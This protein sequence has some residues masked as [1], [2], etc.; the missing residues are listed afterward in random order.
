MADRP[1]RAR[2]SNRRLGAEARGCWCG[3]ART[4]PSCFGSFCSITAISAMWRSESACH[5]ANQSAEGACGHSEAQGANAMRGP[6]NT[7]RWGCRGRERAHGAE[8]LLGEQRVG[9]QRLDVLPQIIGEL[10]RQRVER[11][12]LRVA[13]ALRSF[14]APRDTFRKRLSRAIFSRFVRG[15]AARAAG[16]Q[17][18]VQRRPVLRKRHENLAGESRRRGGGVWG[19][20]IGTQ[21]PGS[22]WRGLREL[23]ASSDRAPAAAA[24]HTL[25]LRRGRLVVAG[26]RLDLERSP[27]Q[28]SCRPWPG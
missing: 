28:R 15:A 18:A 19:A 9:A 1:Q 17:R 25:P 22:P 8:P 3:A 21:P 23:R 4:W 20:R 12:G 5:R 24:S 26:A 16:R 11:R 6:S 10:L 13:A 2:V 27:S 7:R 14:D